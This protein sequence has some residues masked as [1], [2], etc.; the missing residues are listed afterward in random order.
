MN[1]TEYRLAVIREKVENLLKEN[2]ALK[3][4]NSEMAETLEARE[5]TIEIQKNTIAGLTE[6]NKMIK[7]AK[8]LSLSGSDS[9][10]VKIKINE[11]VREIDRCIDLLNE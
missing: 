4:Q 5:K 7:L 10:D 1:G 3:A 11:L 6:R 8:N 9:Y 2:I